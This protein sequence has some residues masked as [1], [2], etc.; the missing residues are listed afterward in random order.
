MHW[1]HS[2]AKD[3]AL[4]F[5]L[6]IKAYSIKQG[7]KS[8]AEYAISLQNSWQV[9]MLL[10]WRSWLRT[11]DLM[12]SWPGSILILTLFELKY[13]QKQNPLSLGNYVHD[14]GWREPQRCLLESKLI[15]IISLASPYKKKDHKPDLW[16]TYCKNV[17]HTKEKCSKL[18]GRSPSLKPIWWNIPVLFLLIW[19]KSF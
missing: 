6:T 15:E 7:E 12:F 13:G 1:S 19:R 18:H 2:K 17:R 14:E 16:C 9:Q 4:V 11:I 3:E 8:I 10:P 5:D